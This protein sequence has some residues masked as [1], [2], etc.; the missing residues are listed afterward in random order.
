MQ[1]DL[2]KRRFSFRTIDNLWGYAFVVIPLI[3]F[4]VFVFV[5]LLM[6]IYASFTSW[7]MGQSI[8]KAKWVGLKNYVTMFNKDLFWQSLGNTFFYLIGIPIGLVLALIGAVA[9]NRGTKY[10]TVFRVIYYVPVISSL[11]AISFVFQRFFMTD[12]GVINN[13]LI[14]IGISNPPNW[15]SN[16]NYTKWVIIV[17]TV[18]KGLGSSIILF[19]AGMQGISTSYYEAAKVDG[20]SFLYSFRKITLPLLMPVTFYLIVTGIIGGMQMYVEP[21]LIFTNNGPS[22]STFT[23][24]IYLYENIFKNSKAG[25]GSAVAVV[26]GVIVFIVTLIQFSMNGRE[27]RKD[28]K[29]KKNK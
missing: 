20:A 18:W 29:A 24:V 2:R 22:N 26:L 21:R 7:P 10:E 5:P 14:A 28:A 23:T 17:L 27:E 13:M 9:M 25:Y 11:V 8:F 15:M 19:I 3:G 12:G 6:S 4:V 16:P 1:Q